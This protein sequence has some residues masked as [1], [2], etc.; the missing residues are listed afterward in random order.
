MKES[1]LNHNKTIEET[2][3]MGFGGSD[4][5]MAI[6]IAARLHNN[7][8]LTITQKK[9]LRIIA[10]LDHPQPTIDTTDITAGRDWED[11]MADRL[12]PNGFEREY[13]MMWHGDPFKN[14]AV[15]AH[16]D[17]FR[18][19]DGMVVECK[20]TH[21]KTPDEIMTDFKWQFAQYALLGAKKVNVAIRIGEADNTIPWEDDG[22]YARQLLASYRLIDLCWD[23]IDLTLEERDCS[24][25][26]PDVAQAVKD[27]EWLKEE[28]ATR[29][30][31][32]KEAQAVVRLWMER[33]DVQK[34]GGERYQLTYTPP[35]QAVRFDTK[36]LQKTYPKIYEQFV[37]Y[38]MRSAGV[39][40]T[41]KK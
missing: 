21:T 32:Y 3:K 25:L 11:T 8:A 24:Q 37:A 1:R 22:D 12:L 10:G 28:I 29:E 17:F 23:K 33:A 7:I 27:M 35:T 34:V 15:F 4:A 36:G 18:L 13:L 38:T 30:E 40:L 41:E 31:K 6:D 14:F 39:R 9:R 5:A 2:R 26:P 20:W 16:A 19:S